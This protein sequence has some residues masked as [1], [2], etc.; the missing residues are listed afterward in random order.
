MFGSSVDT[1]NKR[2]FYKISVGNLFAERHLM[3]ASIHEMQE[4]KLN[5]IRIRFEGRAGFDCLRIGPVVVNVLR[6]SSGTFVNY[7]A[8]IS[9]SRIAV[10]Q[11]LV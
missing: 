3:D 6:R 4:I 5:F 10:L 2:S 9:L 11:I 8:T 7:R 1:K